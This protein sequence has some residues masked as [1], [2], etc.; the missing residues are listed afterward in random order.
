[1]PF[2]DDA[3]LMVLISLSGFA[4]MRAG[5]YAFD[6]D[7]DVDRVCRQAACAVERAKA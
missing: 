6:S 3:A 7:V 1:M 4:A 5:S 2:K